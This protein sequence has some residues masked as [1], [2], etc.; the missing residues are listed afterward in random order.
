MPAARPG[1][2]RAGLDCG[3]RLFSRVAHLGGA[4]GPGDAA[5]AE[6]RGARAAA[7]ARRGGAG[8]AP[9]PPGSLLGG[10]RGSRG[11]GGR[12][13][14]E[15]RAVPS[16]TPSQ[17]QRARRR[18]HSPARRCPFPSAPTRCRPAPPQPRGTRPLHRRHYSPRAV[19]ASPY[20][21]SARTL[22]GRRG[23][24]APRPG[25]P[26]PLLCAAA[27]HGRKMEATHRPAPPAPP[28]PAPRRLPGDPPRPRP[29]PQ[30][31]RFA[32]SRREAALTSPVSR[33]SRSPTLCAAVPRS[34]LPSVRAAGIRYRGGGSA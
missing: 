29:R 27:A 5:P 31:E 6:P 25:S 19:P 11:S 1:T 10:T 21:T 28:G 32:Q 34:P 16:Q 22:R 30:P 13:G 17:P 24:R 15:H 26:P 3:H 7:S 33:P 18:H 2:R 23:V 4:G 12:C 14:G 9:G 8:R 20:L